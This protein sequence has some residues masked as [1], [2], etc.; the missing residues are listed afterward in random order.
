M[1][2]RIFIKLMLGAVLVILIATAVLDLSIRRVWGTSLERQTRQSLQEK[3]QMFAARLGDANAKNVQT[4]NAEVANLARARATVIDSNGNV[5][6]DSEA[7]REEMEN[8]AQRPEFR[9]A[10]AGKVGSDVR[11]SHTIG[12]DFLYVAVP[13]QGGAVRL[14]YPLASIQRELSRTRRILL[15][16]SVAA[17]VIAG[18][19][20][21]AAAWSVARRLRRIMMFSERIASGDL[22]ARVDESSDD[23][24]GKVASALDQTANTIEL[25]FKEIAASRA[26]FESLLNSLQDAVF[27]VDK[28]GRILWA[29]G[30]MHEIVRTR[31]GDKAVEVVRDPDV[32]SAIEQARMGNATSNQRAFTVMP[33]RAYQVS[34]APL[35]PSG[36][37][38]LLHDIT[39]IDRMEKMRRD[40]VANVSHEL[41]TPLTAIQGYAET[42][43]DSSSGHERNYLDIITRNA[44]RMSHLTEDL[45]MLARVESGELKLRLASVPVSEL[46]EDATEALAADAA[47]RHI[48]LRAERST[49]AAVRADKDAI[50]QVFT[51]LISNA[52]N[53][54]SGTDEVLIGADASDGVVD[55][56][57]RDK[58]P[59]ISSEHHPRLFERFY[60]IDRARSRETGGTGL[61]LAIVKHIVLAHG[62]EV[63]VESK[64]GAGATFHF[65]LP[66]F[67][68]T[69]R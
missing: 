29:N 9:S 57:V 27:A 33:S 62:G 49:E 69:V 50:H 24:I 67:Q 14:A 41:R 3:T 61:G 21:A 10:L 60:R 30:A 54:A 18:L 59:G 19:F 45:L 68:Q 42:L 20:A 23:E 53:Y 15:F 65:T 1:R 43:R 37:V 12:I 64:L 17:L 48:H 39:Q 6:A 8:H 31:I 13:V 2:S 38:V 35:P 5:L 25:N 22:S 32:M 52:L 58:G 36:A 11:R 16:N 66:V 51:N 28:D 46:L 40:F 7:K 55:F 63:S 4:I 34:A 56:W 44:S 47:L 26:Q